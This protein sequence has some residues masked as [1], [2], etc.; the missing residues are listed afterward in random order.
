MTQLNDKE[1]EKIIKFL[2]QSLSKND[3]VKEIITK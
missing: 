1:K 2:K 3:L